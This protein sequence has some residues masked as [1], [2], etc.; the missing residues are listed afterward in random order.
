MKKVA[1]P[2]QHLT[3]TP[4]ALTPT[5][6][7]SSSS[8]SPAARYSTIQAI[9]AKEEFIKRKFSIGIGFP[10]CFSFS[11]MHN[12]PGST[13]AGNGTMERGAAGVA[14]S[15]QLRGEMLA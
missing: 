11:A 1:S 7:K 8:A 6:K 15:A 3:F 13:E 12:L 10:V 14:R 5:P 4:P 9:Q 2:L